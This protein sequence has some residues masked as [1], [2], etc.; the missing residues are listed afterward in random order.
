MIAPLLVV[1]MAEQD[2]L[3][4][5]PT[6]NDPNLYLYDP[7]PRRRRGR[8]HSY[9]RPRKYSYDPQARRRRFLGRVRRLRSYIRR[10]SRHGAKTFSAK[11]LKTANHG[12]FWGGLALGLI[13][14]ST[15]GDRTWI[16]STTIGST[17]TPGTGYRVKLTLVA[18]IYRL[19]FG[20]VNLS[21]TFFNGASFTPSPLALG[22]N[23][24]K[25]LSSPYMW[26]GV[27]LY[28][29]S[30]VDGVPR[31]GM[32]KKF[33]FGLIIGGAYGGGTDPSPPGSPGILTS[34]SP[35]RAGATPLIAAYSTGGRSQTG[36]AVSPAS[37]G[38]T[39]Q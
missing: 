14:G 19:T 28:L 32:I 29:L 22:W 12:A 33:A 4:M 37:A 36:G 23:W 13:A 35:A 1:K 24:N 31:R 16:N 9:R 27:G 26:G 17:G 18:A 34:S 6:A 11:L 39:Y 5:Y 38:G 3:D 30:M 20:S 25:M 15:K 2:I 21:T 10:P 8:R 7:D